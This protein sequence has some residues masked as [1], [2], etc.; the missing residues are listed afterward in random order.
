MCLYTIDMNQE[1]ADAMSQYYKL[2]G[3]YDRNVSKARAK[4][5]RDPSLSKAEKRKRLQAL[6]PKCV[7]CNKPGGTVFSRTSDSLK[8]VCGSNADKCGLN[9]DILRG[10]MVNLVDEAEE[11]SRDA[12]RMKMEIVRTKLDYLFGY[13]SEEEAMRRFN[14][15]APKYNDAA[16]LEASLRKEEFDIMNNTRNLASI[17]GNRRSLYGLKK[18]LRS[19]ADQYKSTGN[20]RFIDDMVEKYIEDIQPLTEQTRDLKYSYAAVECM[21]PMDTQP[22][23]DGHFRLVEDVYTLQDMQIS[24]GPRPAVVANS[25][26]KK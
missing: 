26:V 13:V 6:V 18:D 7:N 25:M 5:V 21:N 8:A 1:V 9:I 11:S 4:I 19:L 23:E 14:S 15:Q 3:K 20:E 12:L 10:F 2:K 24:L 16:A 22:C 17:K